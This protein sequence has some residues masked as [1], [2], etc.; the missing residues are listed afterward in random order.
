M[1]LT[2]SNQQRYLR[3][4]WL[5]CAL[6]TGVAGAQD[7][8][9]SPAVTMVYSGNLDG[10]LEPCGCTLEGDFG[11]ILRQATMLDELR[12]RHPGLIAVSS[13]GLLVSGFASDRLKSEFILRGFAGLGYD[14]VGIQW[15]DLAFGARF[16]SAHAMPWVASNWKAPEFSPYR[17]IT[18][19]GRK[20]AVFS[21]LDPAT[22]PYRDMP[23]AGDVIET[24]GGVLRSALVHAR[25][26]NATTVL[27]TSLPMQDAREQLP[28]DDVDILVVRSAYEVYGEPFRDGRTLVLQPGSRGM[29]LGVLDFAVGEGGEILSWNHRVIPLGVDVAD[30]PRLATWYAEY[31]QRVEAAYQESVRQR[32]A[33]EAG[34]SPFSGEAACASCHQETHAI[35]RASQHSHAYR[36]LED[37]NKAFDPECIVCHT[38]G[39][40]TPGG[41]LDMDTTGH[42]S[43]VQCEACHGPARAHVESGGQQKTARHDWA[44]ADICARCHNKSH[45]PAFDFSQYWPKIAH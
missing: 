31:N 17:V 40:D 32:K 7:V 5:V 42:L 9:P 29:R 45:S 22:S 1:I 44:A 24:D 43:N 16:L 23:G 34:E 8:A 14:A 37:V 20:I 12:G 26:D 4:A 35:W 39:F 10:E 33:V 38:V 11:G 15:N 6:V 2:N 3:L 13:G 36:K 28:L 25:R 27:L 41:F 21:W 18:A 19:G 30:S